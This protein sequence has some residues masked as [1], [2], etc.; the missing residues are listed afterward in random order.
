MNFFKLA[1]T[2]SI[3]FAARRLEWRELVNTNGPPSD[4]EDK[5]L[6]QA[7]PPSG[8]RSMIAVLPT[9]GQA[10]V[11][12]KIYGYVEA[13]GRWVRI[14]EL[15]DL[16]STITDEGNINRINAAG[17]SAIYVDAEGAEAHIGYSILE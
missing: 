8:I 17:F 9:T 10:P 6:G 15:D 1:S 16:F 11:D 14:Q 13:L 12:A 5:T 7:L 4:F 3:L 2:L